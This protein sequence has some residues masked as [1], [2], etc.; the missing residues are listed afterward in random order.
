MK[1]SKFNKSEQ[2]LIE[3]FGGIAF[4]KQIAIADAIGANS[5]SLDMIN[6]K[7]NFGDAVEFSFK[8]L[9]SFSRTTGTWL[10]AWANTAVEESDESLLHANKLKAYGEENDVDFLKLDS[11]EASNID[12]HLIGLTASG[13]LKTTGYYIADY[14]TGAMV[15]TIQ[16]DEIL[17]KEEIGCEKIE[18]VFNQ[19]INDFDVSQRFALKFY[20]MEKGYEVTEIGNN[21]TA[22]HNAKTIFA[23]FDNENNLTKLNG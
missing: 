18:T 17:T 1:Y 20:L 9:G 5:W 2:E 14:G 15:F 11:F 3:R 22:T 4:D 6:E 19:L 21:L 16:N 7:I 8:I 10:W 13:F 12:L 23:E